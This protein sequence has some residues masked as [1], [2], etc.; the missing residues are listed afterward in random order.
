[1]SRRT[2]QLHQKLVVRNR[3]ILIGSIECLRE[4]DGDRYFIIMAD[5]TL[6]G[7]HKIAVRL[8]CLYF[9][10]D[11]HVTLVDEPQIRGWSLVLA[12]P[13]HDMGHGVERDELAPV[14]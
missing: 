6:A 4:Q 9:E 11:R 13:E 3:I 10:H 8:C 12:W 1:M 2:C 7:S 5:K 14:L